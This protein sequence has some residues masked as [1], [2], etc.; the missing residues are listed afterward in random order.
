VTTEGLDEPAAVL[1]RAGV[2]LEIEMPIKGPG[3]LTKTLRVDGT[4]YGKS[5][6]SGDL[7]IEDRGDRPKKIIRTPRIGIDYA[8]AYKDK[9]WRFLIQ[10]KT[11]SAAR[12]I[13]A[14]EK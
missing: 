13:S 5:A 4:I 11:P 14:S 1:I 7:C 12:S 9:K 10:D 8:G 6:T 2:M 3:T